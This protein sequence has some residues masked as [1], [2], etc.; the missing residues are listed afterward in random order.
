M[1]GRIS[2]LLSGTRLDG[3][4]PN[5]KSTNRLYRN[6][7]D[8]KFRDVTEKAGL[9]RTGWA[10]SVCVGDYDNDGFDDLFIS[11]Y[12]KNALYHNNGA[13]APSRK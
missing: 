6:N 8:G 3:L 10:Q 2:F 9:I 13:V 4:P 5:V 1:G 7:G 11:G 12:G